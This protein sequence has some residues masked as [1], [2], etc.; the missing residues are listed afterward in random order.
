MAA[1]AAVLAG[2]DIV[3]YGEVVAFGEDLGRGRSIN[4]IAKAYSSRT[5]SVILR[6]RLS[7]RYGQENPVAITN[8]L[9]LDFV[10]MIEDT[11]QL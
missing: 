11:G 10:R 3:I 8:Q 7:E 5:K 9:A 1:Q 4:F 2:A 6:E